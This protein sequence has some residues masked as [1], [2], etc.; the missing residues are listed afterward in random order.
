MAKSRLGIRLDQQIKTK[1]TTAALLSGHKNLTDY[2]ASLLIENS[3]K[4]IA[5]HESI[6]VE[7]DFFDGFMKACEKVS[8]PNSELTNAV[9]FSKDH[10]FK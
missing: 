7:N 9:Q 6:T 4:V 10:G 5:Q 1:A 2:V 8:K 3:T